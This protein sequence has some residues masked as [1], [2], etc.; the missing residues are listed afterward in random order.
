[1]SRSVT[2]QTSRTWL[3]I[4]MALVITAGLAA[5]PAHAF[6]LNTNQLV[7]AANPQTWTTMPMRRSC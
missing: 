6:T 3:V 2:N 7:D 5:V 1:M 4:G